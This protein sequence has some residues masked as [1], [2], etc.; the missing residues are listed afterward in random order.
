MTEPH[1]FMPGDD[2]PLAGLA[3]DPNSASPE[4]TLAA[5]RPVADHAFVTFPARPA[6]AL[7]EIQGRGISNDLNKYGHYAVFLGAVSLI[8][9]AV[10][11]FG[12]GLWWLNVGIGIAGAYYGVKGYRAAGRRLATNGGMALAGAIMGGLGVLATIAY[13]VLV[14]VL[15][16]AVLGGV[17]AP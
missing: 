7:D 14:A 4:A 12:A 16:A 11:F 8:A 13:L 6:S 3:A 1:T 10:L 9:S 17:G 2:D 5:A 15:V